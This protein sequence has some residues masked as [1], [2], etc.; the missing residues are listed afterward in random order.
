[1]ATPKETVASKPRGNFRGKLSH[2]SPI[3]NSVSEKKI[4]VFF[5]SVKSEDVPEVDNEIEIIEDEATSKTLA[6]HKVFGRQKGR[7]LPLYSAIS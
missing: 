1:M 6:L 4:T 7:L 5:S 3:P 2:T